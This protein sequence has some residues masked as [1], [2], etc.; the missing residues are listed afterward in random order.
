MLLTVPTAPPQNISGQ[1]LSSTLIMLLWS[2]PP[3]LDANGIVRHY[4]VIAVERY[5]GRQW[6]F[7]AVDPDL[8]VG[9]LHPYYYYDFNISATTIGP[10]PF[11]SVFTLLTEPER[12]ATQLS[13]SF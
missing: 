5:T 7:F 3:P 2:P 1:A 4:T 6:T 13:L 8:H 12:K 11:S 9:S 10:G